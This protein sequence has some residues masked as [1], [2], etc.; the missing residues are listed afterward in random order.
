MATLVC[1]H[2]TANLANREPSEFVEERI[3]YALQVRTQNYI[4]KNDRLKNNFCCIYSI[5]SYMD[6][7][8]EV[9]ACLGHY[10]SRRN[11]CNCRLPL[12]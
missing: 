1:G 5:M 4:R 2:G 10:S 8:L 12:C 3:F 6:V 9:G 7:H 11:L